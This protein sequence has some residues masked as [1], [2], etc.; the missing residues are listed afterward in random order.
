MHAV[1]Q[2][3]TVPQAYAGDLGIPSR[4]KIEGASDENFS[5]AKILLDYQR[6][7]INDL[8]PIMMWDIPETNCRFVR[9]IAMEPTPSEESLKA[10]KQQGDIRIGFAE[11][12]LYSDAE[13]VALGKRA[14]VDYQLHKGDR[15]PLALTDGKNMFGEILPIRTWLNE[16]A[17]RHDLERTR[18]LI[19]VELDDRYAR[20]TFYLTWVSWLAA[21]LAVGIGATFLIDRF[22][23][24]RQL[25]QLRI[26]F[27]A[28]LHDELG[29]DLHVIG[30]LSD[31]ATAA[32]DSPEKA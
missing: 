9:V 30:L 29:A 21:F 3:D 12:E 23:R 7:N 5:D 26:R 17:H 28:D 31:L 15:S 27:A 1:D 10:T 8:G 18:P 11:I 32:V 16:L 14:F 24:T 19:D 13:N 25:D 4:L 2:D 22:L 20:Q 6:E